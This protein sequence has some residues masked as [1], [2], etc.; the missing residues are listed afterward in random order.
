MKRTKKAKVVKAEN[1]NEVKKELPKI[2]KKV[3]GMLKKR[4]IDALSYQR[5]LRKEWEDRLK[6]IE[7]FS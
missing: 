2:W 4:K 7:N 1:W 6:S 5:K 3:A